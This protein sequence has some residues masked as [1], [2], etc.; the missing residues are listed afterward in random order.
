MA[1]FIKKWLNKS[2]FSHL[3]KNGSPTSFTSL[4]CF[5]VLAGACEIIIPVIL[6]YSTFSPCDGDSEDR[7]FILFILTLILYII[8]TRELNKKLFDCVEDRI[9]HIR[10][11]LIEHIRNTDLYSF[12][13]IG[14]EKI[15]TV[16]T[17]D[18]RSVSELSNLIAISGRAIIRVITALI[19]LAF[20]SPTVFF[21]AVLAGCVAGGFYVH[22]QILV[23]Q[24]MEQVREQEKKLFEAFRDMFD[25]FKELKLNS[26]KDNDF[27]HNCL[28]HR[29]S[30]FQELKL[31]A[32]QH[33]INSY[34][35]S[36]G[37]W[38]ALLVA[39]VM[40]FPLWGLFSGDM[41]L[42]FV[43]LVLLLPMAALIENVPRFVLAGFSVQRLYQMQK[44]LANL[45]AEQQDPV[46]EIEEPLVFEKLRYENIAFM[47]EEN[48]RTAFSVGPLTISV[49]AGDIVF[50]TGGN[51]S[52]KSTL[53]KLMA[54]LYHSSSGTI[55]LNNQKIKITSYRHLFSAV[56][57]D[58]HLSDRLY[59]MTHIDKEKAEELLMLVQLD[60]KVK[61]TGMAFSTLDL[62]SGQRKRLALVIAVLEDRPVY[63]FDEWAADQDPDFRQY[64]YETLLPEFKSRGKTVIA[65]THDDH[66]FHVADQVLK[67]DYGQMTDENH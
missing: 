20:L 27:F 29:S 16:L 6:F 14:Q 36:Y 38:K 22:S 3:W 10:L 35:V 2:D 51:G 18:V 8:A 45:D 43:G 21:L 9:A 65:V 47:Y 28:R 57:A 54:G 46:S 67:I 17:S 4:V 37:S 7:L 58:F 25:G 62:S 42:I 49:H 55:C 32:H 26:K 50:I 44:I 11:R 63:L 1:F 41:L 5:G 52:G 12:E 66:Y 48:G 40:I 64:F 23:R 53:L 19:Y 59:G 60:E 30:R 34:T 56:F 39:I 15:Y 24:V 13:K 33:T 61:F 31:L